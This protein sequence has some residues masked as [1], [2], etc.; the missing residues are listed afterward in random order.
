MKK[1]AELLA[2]AGELI[3]DSRRYLS[4][5]GSV[6]PD[7]L[8]RRIDAWRNDMAIA[9]AAKG[10]NAPKLGGGLTPVQWLRQMATMDRKRD[11]HFRAMEAD[12]IADWLEGRKP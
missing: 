10:K 1:A 4:E 11:A 6:D 5:F 12:A 3:T 7:S 2:E 8:C 9:G